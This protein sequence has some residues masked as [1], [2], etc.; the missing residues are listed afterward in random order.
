[1]F[2]LK[3]SATKMRLGVIDWNNKKR[4]QAM[5]DPVRKPAAM[6]SPSFSPDREKSKVLRSSP[7]TAGTVSPSYSANMEKSGGPGYGWSLGDKAF[8]NQPNAGS[9]SSIKLVSSNHPEMMQD[10]PSKSNQHV[11]YPPVAN[12]SMLTGYILILH[13]L[14]SNSL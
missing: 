10:V 9:G 5:L 8:L 4:S 7:G 12:S 6:T 2:Q 13:D 14:Q 1:M 3:P 11:G